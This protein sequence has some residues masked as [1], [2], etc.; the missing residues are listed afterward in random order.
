MCARLRHRNRS[1]W[2]FVSVRHTKRWMIPLPHLTFCLFFCSSKGEIF[3]DRKQWAEGWGV[4]GYWNCN[5]YQSQLHTVCTLEWT[6]IW[7]WS[8][9]RDL[10]SLQTCCL[11][12]GNSRQDRTHFTSHPSHTRTHTN[13]EVTA[14]VC[15]SWLAPAP[16]VRNSL[17][18][19]DTNWPGSFPLSLTP[20]HN[21]ILYSTT[22]ISWYQSHIPYEWKCS[23]TANLHVWEVEICLFS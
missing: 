4:M 13:R 9:E 23:L 20:A 7:R 19:W 5:V 1:Q 3:S 18:V 21:D 11:T 6:V 15:S 22:M 8:M 10:V 2:L 16:C 14:P 12:F 17:S